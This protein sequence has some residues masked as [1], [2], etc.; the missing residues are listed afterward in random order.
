[1]AEY[2]DTEITEIQSL[3]LLFIFSSFEKRSEDFNFY[4]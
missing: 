4:C 2:V 1:M 3:A